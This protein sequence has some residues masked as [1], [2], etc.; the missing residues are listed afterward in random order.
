MRTGTKRGSKT[1]KKLPSQVSYR[2]PLSS[3]KEIRRASEQTSPQV[4]RGVGHPAQ[5]GRGRR[6]DQWQQINPPFRVSGGSFSTGG[7]AR[8]RRDSGPDIQRRESPQGGWKGQGVYPGSL[9]PC[10]RGL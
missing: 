4:A 1:P 5:A 8:D 6:V 10:D 3:N 9:S 7:I 2:H